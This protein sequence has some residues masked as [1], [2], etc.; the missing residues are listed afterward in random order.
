VSAIPHRD[1]P[2]ATIAIPDWDRPAA[3]GATLDR[4]RL[5][6][7]LRLVCAVMRAHAGG[8]ELVEVSAAGVVRLRFTG[9]CAGCAFRPL[10]MAG[11]IVPALMAVPGVTGAR[12]DGARISDEAARRMQRYL[13]DAGLAPLPA[14]SD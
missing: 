8:V 5:E 12:A 3:S 9:M 10:T 2:A 7:R 6:E 14:P 4:D 11:T 1:R 13:G